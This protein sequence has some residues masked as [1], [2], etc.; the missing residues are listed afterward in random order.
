MRLAFAGTPEFA[1]TILTDLIDHD[2]A[3]VMVYTQP[4]RPAGRGR[5]LVPSP[6]K[7][8]ALRAGIGIRQPRSL[9]HEA[10]EPPDLDVLVVAAYGLLLPGHVLRAPRHG[11]VNVHA[12]LLPRWRGAAPVERA[13]MAGDEVTGVSIMQMD[14]GLDTGPVFSRAELPISP[15]CSGGELEAELAKLGAAA[16]RECLAHLEDWAPEPQGAG[17]SYAPKLSPADSEIDWTRPARRLADQVRA[18][19]D[20][21]PARV[22][23]GE[24][25]VQVL[26]SRPGID[27]PRPDTAPGTIVATSK[28][29][30]TVACGEGVLEITR[31]KLNRGKGTPLDAAAA[32]NGYRELFAPGA[33]LGAT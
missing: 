26:E 29:A 27:E 21:Q 30:I 4:D 3:P 1:A 28:R 12:S 23:I 25:I 9:K 8:V 32:L 33:T 7:A 5:R 2:L 22:R 20:R 6:V 19:R 13:I 11:C 14:E 18:L 15:E 31:L 24:V 17:A 16:L 10:L